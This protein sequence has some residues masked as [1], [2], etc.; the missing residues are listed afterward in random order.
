MRRQPTLPS[1]GVDPRLLG[2]PVVSAG[3]VCG[4]VGCGI[5]RSVWRL[6]VCRSRCTAVSCFPLFRVEL[7]DLLQDRWWARDGTVFG[8]VGVAWT[9]GGDE[10]ALRGS[11]GGEECGD[12]WFDVLGDP[13]EVAGLPVLF[14]CF[15]FV[16]VVD[17]VDSEASEFVEVFVVEPV[18]GHQ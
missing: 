17:A 2:G 9:V 6:T 8:R 18:G 13:V 15:G 4:R 11:V 14:A 5:V 16:V 12:G 10:G 3:C 7:P 1:I